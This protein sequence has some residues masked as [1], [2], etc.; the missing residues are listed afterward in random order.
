M[1]LYDEIFQI[2]YRKQPSNIALQ[3]DKHTYTYEEV[4]ELVMELAENLKNAGVKK[5]SKAVLKMDHPVKFTFVLLALTYLEAVPMPIYHGM[6]YEKLMELCRVYDVNFV[7]TDREEVEFAKMYQLVLDKEDLVTMFSV[8][9]EIDDSLDGTRL[10]LFTSGTTSMPKAIMLTEENICTNV[11]GISQYLKLTQQDKILLI[12]DLSHSSSIIGELFVGFLN[13]CS[14]MMT[15]KLLRAITILSLMQEQRT[16]VFFG[17][18][19]LLKDIMASS[20]RRNYDISSLRIINFYGA[21]MNQND[22]LH[23][24]EMFPDTNIIYSYGQTEASPRVTYIEKDMLLKHPASSGR[25]IQ[26]VSVSIV[27]SDGNVCQ[28]NETGEVVVEGPN[29]MRGYY[30]NEEKT[31][32]MIRNHKLFTGDLAHMDE[33]GFLYVT[34]RKDNMFIRGGKNIYPEEIEGVLNSHPDILEALIEAKNKTNEVV[35]IIAYIVLKENATYDA[36]AIWSHCKKRL[37]DYKVPKELNVVESLKKT[38]SG[39]IMRNQFV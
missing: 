19:T 18:P 5:N 6:G 32:K 17:V 3:C 2:G 22:I 29:V 37:E 26:N 8:E 20:K 34:G 31:K 13:G 35:E 30:R 12:K 11:K 1:S 33:E 9:Q 7:L 21:S 24:I 38:P 4:H 14:I 23:L 28:P 15:T 25:P 39:K 27:D 36:D 16:T 10:I